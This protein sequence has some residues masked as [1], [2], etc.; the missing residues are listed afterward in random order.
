[1]PP[2]TPSGP[3]SVSLRGAEDGSSD[4]RSGHPRKVRRRRLVAGGSA[5]GSGGCVAGVLRPCGGL[6]GL[7]DDEAQLGAAGREAFGGIGVVQVRQAA[8]AVV[9]REVEE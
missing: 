3:S 7:G 4:P 8:V 6:G 1:M 5:G 2:P 9:E